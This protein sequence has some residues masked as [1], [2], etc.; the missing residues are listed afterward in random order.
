[1]KIKSIFISDVH[2]GCAHTLS[3]QLADCLENIPNIPPNIFLVGDIF[4]GWKLAKGGWHWNSDNSRIV[5]SLLEMSE[6]RSRIIYLVGNHDE[7]LLKHLKDYGF[8]DVREEFIYDNGDKKYLIIHGDYFDSVIRSSKIIGLI[9][10]YGYDYVLRLNSVLRKIAI[11]L[12]IRS[13]W[14]LSSVI[15]RNVKQ[16]CTFISNFDHVSTAYAKQK[17]CD[18]LV[19]GHIHTPHVSTKNGFEY[20]NCGDWVEHGTLLVEYEDNTKE[21]LSYGDIDWIK[22]K[23]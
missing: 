4:D 9:G 8:V 7:F 23:N 5:K 6:K 17:G 1:M 22:D 20:Y 16:V 12:N 11:K 15:K 2:L 13:R 21:L 19:C 3:R 18:G 10:D 14:S